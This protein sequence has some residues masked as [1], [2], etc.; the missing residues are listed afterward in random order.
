[1]DVDTPFDEFLNFFKTLFAEI[2]KK[3]CRN[4]AVSFT[5]RRQYLNFAN[6][7]G[8]VQVSSLHRTTL[9]EN[10]D[11]LD[12]SELIEG[13]ALDIVK[14][15]FEPAFQRKGYGLKFFKWLL[16]N[17]PTDFIFIQCVTTEK[18]SNFLMKYKTE[19]NAAPR[20]TYDG[21][22]ST[23][24]DTDWVLLPSTTA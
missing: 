6:E 1:M 2:E 3:P 5:N 15:A 7:F 8:E 23:G 4:R 10:P 13:W 21:T 9:V 19:L 18:L 24:I 12:T 22:F 14:I 16:E 11:D 20:P 17:T